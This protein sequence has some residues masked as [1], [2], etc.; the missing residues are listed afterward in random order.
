MKASGKDKSEW[1]P[2]VGILL[3]LKKKLEIA[4]ASAPASAAAMT[5]SVNTA[6]EAVDVTALE[7]AVEEQVSFKL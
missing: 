5:Q 7:K 6:K 1:Q 4:K 3:D 2:Q